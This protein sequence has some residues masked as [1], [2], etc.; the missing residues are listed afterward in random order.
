M[1][2]HRML[3]RSAR[4]VDKIT[5]QRGLK[6]SSMPGEENS[7]ADEKQHLKGRTASLIIVDDNNFYQLL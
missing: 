4:G 7:E 1:L 2:K 6:S 3:H 5:N